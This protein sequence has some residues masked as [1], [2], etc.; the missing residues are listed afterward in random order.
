MKQPIKLTFSNSK[1]CTNSNGGKGVYSEW[2]NEFY[3]IENYF[4]KRLIPL[5]YKSYKVNQ[6]GD[7]VYMTIY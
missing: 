2:K 5:G 3:D 4:K 7:N 1:I 6:V